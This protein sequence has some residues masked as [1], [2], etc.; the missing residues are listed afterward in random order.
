[1]P[2]ISD[3]ID[4]RNAALWHFIETHHPIVLRYTLK[5]DFSYFIF[6]VASD[7]VIDIPFYN[8]SI[9]LLTHELLH[10]YLHIK[11]V[12]VGQ[13]LGTKSMQS[14]TLQKI[15]GDEMIKFTANCLEHD[16]MLPMYLELGYDRNAFVCDYDVA[17]CTQLDI[18]FLTRHLKQANKSWD[19][20][21]KTFVKVYL[22]MN[23]CPNT[24]I[25]YQPFLVSLKII[26]EHLYL[27]LDKFWTSWELF[28]I[29]TLNENPQG[30]TPI[31]DD[32]L[33]EMT[34]WITGMAA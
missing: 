15:Y 18:E 20:A 10:I 28:D 12:H 30:Y 24:T 3:Y 8:Y 32:F 22:G 1:M 13:Y 23:S 27:I 4:E 21:T 9:E 31:C 16:K 17:K 25:D 14:K 33:M 7:V 2:E 11:Q 26:N 6:G 5:K 19:L 29:E 34:D